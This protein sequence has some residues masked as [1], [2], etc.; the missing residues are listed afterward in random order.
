MNT[1]LKEKDIKLLKD[2]KNTNYLYEIE[3]GTIIELHIY[4]LAGNRI[5]SQHG[6]DRATYKVA[7][8]PS[9]TLVTGSVKEAIIGTR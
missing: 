8:Q 7:D 6:V 9:S 3:D 1:L 5:Y 2:F 4:D